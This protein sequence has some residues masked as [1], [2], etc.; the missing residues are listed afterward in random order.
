MWICEYVAYVII[1]TLYLFTVNKLVNVII[2]W[3]CKTKLYIYDIKHINKSH[4]Q[5]DYNTFIK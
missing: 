1:I 4:Y 5:V 2:N 3:L